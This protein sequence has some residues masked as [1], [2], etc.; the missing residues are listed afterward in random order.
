MRLPGPFAFLALA[1]VLLAAGFYLGFAPTYISDLIPGHSPTNCGSAFLPRDVCGSHA[2]L[3]SLRAPAIGLLVASA[4][5][6]LRS[7][8]ARR[9]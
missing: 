2:G 5:C 1:V 3:D 6:G 7:F 9:K 4:L 8:T